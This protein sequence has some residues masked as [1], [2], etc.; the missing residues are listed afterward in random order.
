MWKMLSYLM[1]ALRPSSQAKVTKPVERAPGSTDT[2]PQKETPPAAGTTNKVVLTDSSIRLST[3]FTLGEFTNS[4]V[5]AR[6]GIDNYPTPEQYRALKA[7]CINLLQPLRNKLKRPM[8]ISSGFRSPEL[9]E[10]LSSS[11]STSQH[12]LGEAADI[13]AV[14]MSALDLARYIHQSGLEYDQLILEYY[15]GPGT[16]WVHISF[17]RSGNKRE[18][19][20]INKSGVYRGLRA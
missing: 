13:H 2:P 14:G 9:N 5:A 11:S 7:L 8:V 1:R 6:K 10:A 18:P 16:G 12:M 15:E 4:E 19:L 20:T 3:N 17:K